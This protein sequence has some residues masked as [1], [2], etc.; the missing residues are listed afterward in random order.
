M[1]EING[2]SGPKAS[3]EGE[4]ERAVELKRARRE[5]RRQRPGG[6]HHDGTGNGVLRRGIVEKGLN[7]FHD[8]WNHRPPKIIDLLDDFVAPDPEPVVAAPREDPTVGLGPFENLKVGCSAED[9]V[10]VLAEN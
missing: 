10:I 4:T 3:H 9:R 8:G 7:A 5:H 6:G 2:E 1:A